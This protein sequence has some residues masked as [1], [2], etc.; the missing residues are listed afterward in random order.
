MGRIVPFRIYHKQRLPRS[1]DSLP[2]VFIWRT[3][4]VVMAFYPLEVFKHFFGKG[5]RQMPQLDI[6][7]VLL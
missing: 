1:P 7:Q 2:A 6:V 4:L 3:M 5:K